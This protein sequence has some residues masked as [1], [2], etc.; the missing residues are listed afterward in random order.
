MVGRL[1]E[2]TDGWLGEWTA[3]W[4]MGGCMLGEWMDGW[5]CC[6][7]NACFDGLMVVWLDEQEGWTAGIIDHKI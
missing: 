5:W 1:G 3:R 6:W 2:S 4:R 7:M